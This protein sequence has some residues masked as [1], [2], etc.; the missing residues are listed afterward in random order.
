MLLLEV[1][2]DV[3]VCGLSDVSVWSESHND[4]VCGKSDDGIVFGEADDSPAGGKSLGPLWHLARTVRESL[5][6][7]VA[8][9]RTK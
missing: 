4:A 5:T 6:G 1:S 9:P 7:I 2:A 8:R 3:A